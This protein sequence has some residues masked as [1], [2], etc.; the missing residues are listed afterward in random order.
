MLFRSG[1]AGGDIT[2]IIGLYPPEEKKKKKNRKWQSQ[3]VIKVSS[4]VQKLSPSSWLLRWVW[5]NVRV[6][7]HLRTNMAVCQ[8][9]T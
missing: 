8:S 5:R 1:T 4:D 2:C 7:T 6:E 9:V 3:L